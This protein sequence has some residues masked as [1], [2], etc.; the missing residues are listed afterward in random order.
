MNGVYG[1]KDISSQSKWYDRTT[2]ANL[3]QLAEERDKRR[4]ELDQVLQTLEK[5]ERDDVVESDRYYPVRFLTDG[6][7]AYINLFDNGA[8]FYASS[9]V[10]LA[11]TVRLAEKGALRGRIPDFTSLIKLAA[12]NSVFDRQATKQAHLVRKMRNSYLHYYNIMI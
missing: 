5:L 4:Q 7:D 9:A 10:E 2:E 6:V 3:A 8:V 11:I 1:M 12:D